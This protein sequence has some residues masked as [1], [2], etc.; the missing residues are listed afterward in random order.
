MPKP[1]PTS[2]V[3]TRT[4][5]VSSPSFSA[6]SSLQPPDPLAGE[7]DMQPRAVPFGVAAAR[8]HRHSPSPGCRPARAGWCAR[9]AAKVAGDLRLVAERP[10]VG[11]VRRRLGVD[12]R[13]ARGGRHVHRQI[14]RSRRRSSPPRRA[15]PPGSRRRP[16]RSPRRRSA[17][18]RRPASAGAAS[19]PREPS[20]LRTVAKSDRVLQLARRGRPRYRPRARPAPP[21]PRRRRA[22][23]MRAC[24][25]GL[26]KNTACSAPAGATSSM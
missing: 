9:R 4:A 26:R 12:R 1:P 10:V 7:A 24:A 15:P 5:S 3:V 16:S 22:P 20:R 13:P 25:T 8:L 23:A 11:D 18:G 6:S 2:G 14:A 17:R 21:P 19:A